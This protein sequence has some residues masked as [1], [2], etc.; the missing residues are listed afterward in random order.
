MDMADTKSRRFM[1][2]PSFL[3]LLVSDFLPTSMHE[4]AIGSV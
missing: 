1:R 2:P 4:V 3:V